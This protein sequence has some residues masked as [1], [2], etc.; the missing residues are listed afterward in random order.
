MKSF[1]MIFEFAIRKGGNG[2]PG[3]AAIGFTGGLICFLWL[4]VQVRNAKYSI[5]SDQVIQVGQK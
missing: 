1:S 2:Y 3:L 4:L 5:F